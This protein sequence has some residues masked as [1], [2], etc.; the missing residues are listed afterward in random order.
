MNT[1]LPLFDS[2]PVDPKPVPSYADDR[3]VARRRAF[4]KADEIFIANYEKC[5]LQIGTQASAFIAAEVTEHY[6]AVYG[7]L[8]DHQAKALGGLYGDLQRRRLI[9]KTG[10]HRARKNGNMAA[11]YR[12]CG[13][14][15][16]I[17]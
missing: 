1:G 14:N 17:G 15:R 4:A 16:I 11:E 6:E 7:K 9:E 13:V 2:I 8:A 3:R 12:L 5:V 10:E